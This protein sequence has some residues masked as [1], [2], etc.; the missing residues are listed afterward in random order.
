MQAPVVTSSAVSLRGCDFTQA[1]QV[2]LDPVHFLWKWKWEIHADEQVV[3]KG[4]KLK[5][6]WKPTVKCQISMKNVSY[7]QNCPL[8]LDLSCWTTWCQKS[9]NSCPKSVS[10]HTLMFWWFK[11]LKSNCVVIRFIPTTLLSSFTMFYDGWFTCWFSCS[12]DARKVRQMW[13]PRPF[14]FRL[15]WLLCCDGLVPTK[16]WI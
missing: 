10:F 11:G 2:L 3:T 4:Q 1:T 9:M 14:Y 15:H 5:N 8:F 13:S 16:R 12:S 7:G 6:L